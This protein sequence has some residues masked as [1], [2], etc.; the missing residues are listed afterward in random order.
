M[1]KY[2]AVLLA[3]ALVLLTAVA[4]AIHLSGRTAPAEGALRV[5]KDGKAVELSI[6]G[7]ELEDVQGSVVNGK[8]E[9]RVIDGQGLLLSAALDAAGVQAASHVTVTADD[10]YSVV[11]TAEELSAPDMVYLIQQEDG[12]MQMVVFGD[13]N[14]KRNV[15]NV[16]RLTVE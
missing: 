15:S 1:K 13:A 3:A 6:A 14:S 4:A 7:L 5:E 11:V 10:E 9:T 2:R 8:G 16:A 12:K